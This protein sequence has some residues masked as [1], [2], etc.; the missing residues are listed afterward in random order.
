MNRADRAPDAP[1]PTPTPT[2]DEAD[3]FVTCQECEIDALT[4]VESLCAEWPEQA[5]GDAPA[6]T[7]TSRSTAA[8]T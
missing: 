5:D 8:A 7:S 1:T 3:A 4:F 2:Q 6:W